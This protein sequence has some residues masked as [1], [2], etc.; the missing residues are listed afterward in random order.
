MLRCVA[1]VRTEVSKELS[2]PIIRVTRLGELGTTVAVISNRRMLRRNTKWYFWWRRC[3]VPPKRRFLQ[4]P[5][6]VSSQKT[7]FFKSLNKLCSPRSWHRD[8]SLVP[9]NT[10]SSVQLS[11]HRLRWRTSGSN[12]WDTMLKAGGPRVWERMR[13]MNYINLPNPFGR[14][15]SWGLLSL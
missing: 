11:F 5:H 14:I 8:P 2:P 3:Y 15:R 10:F 6:G 4:Q 7:P 12:G 9:M 13:L 1:L